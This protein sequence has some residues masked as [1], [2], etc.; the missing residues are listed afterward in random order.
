[1]DGVVI[2]IILLKMEVSQSIQFLSSAFMNIP[3]GASCFTRS[4]RSL[5]QALVLAYLHSHATPFTESRVVPKKTLRGHLNGNLLQVEG[6][7]HVV[8]KDGLRSCLFSEPGHLRSPPLATCLSL[9]KANTF[10][11]KKTQ[12]SVMQ[13]TATY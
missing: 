4:H 8:T 3:L 10:L 1:M 2:I 9:Q 7:Q 11:Y 12:Y 6:R 5:G 13:P